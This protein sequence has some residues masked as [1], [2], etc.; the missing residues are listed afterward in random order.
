[1]RLLL[2]IRGRMMGQ[3]RLR[4]SLP[5]IVCSLYQW[6]D[7]FAAARNYALHHATGDWIVSIDADEIIHESGK[8]ARFA[9]RFTRKC[10]RCSY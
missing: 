3:W 2:L 7:D 4:V 8:N 5:H 9:S 1:M 10:R 6:N